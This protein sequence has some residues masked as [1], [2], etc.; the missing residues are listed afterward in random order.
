MIHA[1]EA[2]MRLRLGAALGT[3]TLRGL[4][5]RTYLTAENAG[6]ILA[7]EQG[8][9]HLFPTGADDDAVDVLPP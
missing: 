3:A 4:A 1:P 5:I 6:D 2:L 8:N 7:L 9:E